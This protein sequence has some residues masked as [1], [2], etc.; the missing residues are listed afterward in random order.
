MFGF[1]E[2]MDSAVFHLLEAL[3]TPPQKKDLTSGYNLSLILAPHYAT[4]QTPQGKAGVKLANIV[5]PT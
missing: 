3:C 5:G 2:I 1:R 4:S